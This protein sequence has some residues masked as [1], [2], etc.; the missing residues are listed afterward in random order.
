MAPAINPIFGKIAGGAPPCGNPKASIAF[1]HDSCVAAVSMALALYLRLGAGVFTLSWQSLLTMIGGSVLVAVPTFL[2]S[3]MYRGIWRYASTHDLINIAKASTLAILIFFPAMFLFNR[4]E[5]LPRS[6]P[7]IQWCLLIVLLGGARF[8]YRCLRDHRPN[9]GAQRAG[10]ATIPVL[11]LGA[12]DAAEQFIRATR[13]DRSG[14]YRAVAVLDDAD[15]I[16]GL[17]IHGTPVL[18]RI[19]DLS[20]AVDQ[21]ARRRRRPQRVIMTDPGTIEPAA[22]Q[23]LLEQADALGLTVACLPRLTEFKDP[24][25]EG[26]LELRPIALEDLLGRPQLTLR[27]AAIR[28]LIEGRRILVTGAGGTI[29]S[30][31]ARQIAARCPAELVLLDSGEFQL[32][33]ID[34]E[35]R[36]RH[37]ELACRPV[38]CNIRERERVMQICA[39]YRPELVFHAAALK[40]VPM[41][42]LNPGEG[43]LTNVIGTRNV[44]DAAARYGALAMVQVSSDKAVKPTSMMGA[45]KRLAEFYCQ[46]LDLAGVEDAET[47]RPPAR[48]MTVRF[49]N[50]LGSSGSVVPLF[51]R[52]LAQGGPLTVTHPEIERYFMTV[53]EAV[54]LVLQASAHGVAHPEARGQIFVLDMGKP[55]K[56][57]D[58]ARQMIRL[59][60]LRPDLDVKL[61]F[62]GLRPGE[63]LYEELF[64]DNEDRLPAAVEGVL[65]ARSLSINLEVL[66][67]AFDELAAIAQRED[68]EALERQIAL[69]LPSFRQAAG[70][71]AGAAA[72]DHAAAAKAAAV[73]GGRPRGRA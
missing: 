43:V 29:G 61:E 1:L 72:P 39:G 3:G 68:Q 45:S 6:V 52:Q 12:G 15:G 67:R 53:R 4:L 16:Q 66:R 14:L 50:V 51:Q 10:V 36:E 18:G 5:A 30:E 21:L 40:H 2:L 7:V 71:A 13:T 69:V 19:A 73:A 57:V 64:D 54:E 46:S 20:R 33:S 28:Q 70:V 17:Q 27:Q 59:A 24:A 63:K 32:Y 23:R 35:L 42:E 55:A 48:F 60:G 8:T 41:V 49:G 37:P 31:L 65:V 58:V 44:A 9:R 47:G 22:K 11:L 38:L 34:L 56:I 62:T 25:D 26:S